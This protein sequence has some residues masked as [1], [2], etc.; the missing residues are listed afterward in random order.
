VPAPA[1]THDPLTFD[2][3]PCNL[4][5]GRDYRVI[6]ER[7]YPRLDTLRDDARMTTD[8]F[9]NYGRIVRCRGCDLVF[10]TPRPKAETICGSYADMQD[11]DYCREQECRSMNA[12]LAMRLIRRHARAGGKL[13]DIGCST[14]FL[15]NAARLDFEPHGVEP[16]AWAAAHSI[17]RLGLKDVTRGFFKDGMFP[18]ETFDVVTMVDVIEH[19]GDPK[20]DLASIRTIL[21]PGGALYLVTPNISSLSARLL[22]GYWWGLRPAHIYYFSERTLRRMLDETGFTVVETRSFGRIFTLDYWLGRLRNYPKPVSWLIER[23]IALFGVRDK[24]FYLNTRDSVELVAIRK[25]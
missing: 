5:G 2:E 17:D 7:P 16:S 9:G 22:G 1:S 8:V 23:A 15:L 12:H 24:I 20:S 3:V 6:F 19:V 11:E 14:G 18:P 13:L 10:T 4:C 25:T 21:K